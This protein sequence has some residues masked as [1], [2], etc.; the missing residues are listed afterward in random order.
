MLRLCKIHNKS[1]LTN[2]SRKV[3]NIL[4]ANS[5]LCEY[6]FSRVTVY[7]KIN[8][9]ERASHNYY[10]EKEDVITIG[11]NF[12]RKIYLHDRDIEMKELNDR[13]IIQKMKTIL[14]TVC[15]ECFEPLSQLHLWDNQF[16]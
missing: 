12:E 4:S 10:L 3:K 11:L 5:L 1:E 7:K 14:D 2:V 8:E 6:G 15:D 13:F 9:N 16:L